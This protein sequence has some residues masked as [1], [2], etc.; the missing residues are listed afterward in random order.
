[1]GV[2][3]AR[4]HAQWGAARRLVD[5]Y[6]GSECGAMGKHRVRRQVQVFLGL[7]CEI[8]GQHLLC[9][10]RLVHLW[11]S[12]QNALSLSVPRTAVRRHLA[13]VL[14]RPHLHHQP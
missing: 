2:H 6:P 7:T 1:M 13:R 5:A 12:Y 11:H 10:E 8:S 14:A 3:G 9:S 4:W